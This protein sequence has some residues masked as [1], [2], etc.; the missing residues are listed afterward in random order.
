MAQSR[1]HHRDVY[2]HTLEVLDRV[3]ALHATLRR[4]WARSMPRRSRRC[5][6]SRSPTG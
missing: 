4:S 6:P 3:I 2:G 1:Y 5:S